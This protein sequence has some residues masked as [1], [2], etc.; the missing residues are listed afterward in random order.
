M[1]IKRLS[2]LALIFSLTVCLFAC[3]NAQKDSSSEEEAEAAE[4]SDDANNDTR[5]NG[6]IYIL[7]TS[8]VHCG[9]NQG[10][11]YAGLKEI[12]DNLEAQGY[13]VILVDNG[14]SIQG[15][16][17]GMLTEGESVIEIM[18]ET[19]YDLW[20]PGNHEFDYGMEQFFKLVDMADFKVISCNFNKEGELLYS[21]Y[22]VLEA[23]GKKIGFVGVTTP[24]T[25]VSSTPDNFK[26]EE[27]EFIYGF[28]QDKSGE[29]LYE[30]VQSAVDS[31]RAEGAE[32]VYLMAHLGML[33][34]DAP[35]TYA[36]VIEHTNGIDVV[37]DGHSHDTEQ[38]VMKNKDGEDVVRSACGTKLGAI[39]YSHISAE[40]GIVDTNI[41]TWNNKVSMPELI[42]IDNPVNSKIESE[43]EDLNATL[44]TVIATAEVELTIF[45]P[46]ET[47]SNGK[48]I[49][50]VR[51][52]ETNAADFCAD[53]YKV[54][55][56]ADIVLINGGGVRANIEKGE[57]TYGDV[58]SIAPFNNQLALIE[59]TGQQILDALEFG[60]KDVPSEFGGF[61]QVSG[62]TYEFDVNIPSGCV[63]DETG[64]LTEING[65]RRVKNVLVGGE[66]IDPEKTYKVGGFDYILTKNGDGNTAFNGA[67]VI[68]ERIKT[69]SQAL[70]EYIQ[71]DLEGI[72]GTGYEDPYGEGRIVVLQG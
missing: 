59:A 57:V 45:D 33:A 60:V 22:A 63:V 46:T 1:K 64:M 70:I 23:A 52:S 29:L 51:R 66:P 17:I 18:N 69:D 56:G 8:D 42:G 31:A 2:I 32:Y 12:K 43:M 9:A 13:A 36:D 25:F 10:F 71:G 3:G 49:R 28:L 48:P 24:T 55:T 62:L 50:M 6:D 67:T 21:P 20:T 58:L 15:E 41:L 11:G 54:A 19:G 26:N 40:E 34:K 5:E 4:T 35:W 16:S 27:G 37:L 47:D 39:G 68:N 44:D 7:F 72:I 30:A 53:A 65:E 14:D 61:L 38:V